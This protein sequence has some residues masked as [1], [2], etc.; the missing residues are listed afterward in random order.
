MIL[1][2]RLLQPQPLGPASADCVT[3]RY[4]TVLSKHSFLAAQKALDSCSVVSAA[5]LGSVTSPKKHW[6]LLLENGV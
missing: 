1:L 2:L 4:A 3:F 6:F 5:A